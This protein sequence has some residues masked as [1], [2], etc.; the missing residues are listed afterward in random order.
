MQMPEP[1]TMVFAICRLTELIQQEIINLAFISL[2]RRQE[3]YCRHIA[4]TLP[5]CETMR[6]LLSAIFISSLAPLL[7]SAQ[8]AKDNW[9]IEKVKSADTILLISHKLIAGSTD[10]AID[11]TGNTVTLPNLIVNN[12]LNRAILKEE[13]VI[14]KAAIDSL[15]KILKRQ[16][17]NSNALQGGCF[18]PRQ[19]IILIK[20][21]QTSYIDICFHCSSYEASKDLQNIPAFDKQKWTDL[22]KYFRERGLTYEL[23]PQFD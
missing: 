5:L 8:I 15:I 17:K 16:S 18:V 4:N 9:L 14:D 23:D 7:A 10:E 1:L 3:F 11:I 12:K 22:E 2:T 13:K 20:G 19:S 21:L 6:R